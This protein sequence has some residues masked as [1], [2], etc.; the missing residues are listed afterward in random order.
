MRT[1]LAPGALGT[2]AALW[3]AACAGE[4]GSPGDD[5][6]P[7]ANLECTAFIS[8]A[9]NPTSPLIASPAMRV[10]ATAVV[11]V[12]VFSPTWTVT[13]QGNPV[14]QQPEQSGNS[15]ISFPAIQPG[16]YVVQ[17]DTHTVG[18][19][20]ARAQINVLASGYKHVDMWLRVT[21]AASSGVPP[22]ERDVEID[23]GGNYSLGA[24]LLEPG[25]TAAGMV[26]S[27]GTGVASYLRLVPHM[28]PD[29]AVEA[30][31]GA[32]GGFSVHVQP[33]SHD[34]L[35]IPQD[36]GHAPR[37]V[38][39]WQP[40]TP[41]IDVGTG[42]A[43]GVKGTV[44]GPSGAPLAGAKVQLKIDQIPSTVATT[45]A[46]G[47]FTLLAAQPSS[48]TSLVAI[49]V[50]PPDVSGLPRLLANS[51]TFD[52]QSPFQI[53]YAASVALRDLQGA[54]VMRG[55]G[56]AR[57]R[58][59]VVGTLP[60]IGTVATGPMASVTA[61]GEVQI[62]G[63]T[64][65]SG[66]LPAMLAP[67]RQLSAVIAVDPAMNDYAV[68]AIDLTSTRP[69]TIDAL[70]PVTIATQ[71]RAPGPGPGGA[72]IADAVLDATP[73]GA[74]AQAGVTAVVRATS[75]MN[76]RPMGFLAA[77]GQYDLRIHDP[78]LARGAPAVVTG[79]PSQG[80]AASY[81]LMPALRQSGQLML[82]GDPTP[83]GGAA[84]QLLCSSCM[85]LARSRPIAE[86]T[87]RPDG[88]FTLVV[89]D[90]GTN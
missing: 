15:E 30:F 60:G 65:G 56:L 79:V 68:A 66:A 73:A 2:I 46:D 19:P 38:K 83:L 5:V 26:Q 3:L 9:G 69:A 41:T 80:L 77:G 62:A 24:F 10:R 87:S 21:P 57:V 40:G 28:E 12:V 7:D 11:S 45:A 33:G 32:G 58:V 88:T 70:P 71:L 36:A 89:P 48:T 75:D 20:T 14:S 50:T 78:V 74:L 18:C 43:G 51:T 34:V 72:P 16:V 4:V 39:D 64:D 22:F 17:L 27:G 49:D 55:V 44:L 23:G 13:F 76:G 37:L 31:T 85:G 53:S 59:V 61:W 86:T 63:T 54:K 47:T 42:I 6:G 35:V 25:R 67:A 82:Q 81:P 52:L 29:A 84:V 90:P 8:F 1:L